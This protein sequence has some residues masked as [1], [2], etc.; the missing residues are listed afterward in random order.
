MNTPSL[1]PTLLRRTRAAAVPLSLALLALTA[2]AADGTRKNYTL[3]SGDA[4]ATLKAFSQQSG[5]QIVYPVEAVRGVQTKPVTGD[6]TA[7]E[8]LQRMVQGT[9]L[10]VVEDAKTG[11]LA[12][13]PKGATPGSVAASELSKALKLEDFRVLGSRIRQTE[14][15]G[16]SPVSAYDSEYIRS[17]GAFTL[18]DFLNQIPQTYSG[19]ASG[20]GSTPNELNP[21][22][23]QRTE[24]T[25]PAFNLVLGSS[26]APP[27]Q[28]GVSG[29]SLRGLGSASTL[30]LVDGRRVAQS[31]AGNRSTDTRQ[32]FV[33]L[34]TI[35][36]GMIDRVEVITDGASAI[37]GADAVAGVINIVLKKEYSGT[38]VQGSFKTAEHGGGRERNTSVLHGFAYGRLSGTVSLE[39]YDRQNLKAS[40]RRFSKNQDHRGIPTS[41]LTADGSTR[42]GNDFR[43]NWGYPAVI[44]ASGGV[45]AGTFDA[46]PGIRVVA[47]PVGATQTPTLSQFIPITTPV[48]TATVVNATGQRRLNTAP[49]LDLI[50]ESKRKG[51]STTFKY[52]LN[53]HLEAFGSGRTSEVRS[54]S[55]AQVAGNSITGG[56]G[57]AAVL[58]AAFNPF[59]QNVQIGMMLPEWGSANQTV[60]TLSD[61]ATGGL[62]GSIGQSW[63]WELG[64]SYQAG[65]TRQKT[66]TYN[67]AGFVAL[68]TATDPAQRFN[69]F[70]DYTAPGAPSQAALLETLSIYP[71]INTE[72][73]SSGI[74]FTADGDLFPFW[75]GDV[76]MAFGGSYN[77]DEV[78][79][80]AIN[81]SATL[82]PVAT[83][84]IFTSDLSTNAV[85]A[86]LQIPVVGKQNGKFFA[87]RLDFQVAGR[88]EEIGP[89]S[90]VVPKYGVSWAP[91]KSV[92]LRGSWSEGFRAPGV[93]EYLFA[94]TTT[95]STLTD[96]RRTP[97]STTGVVVTSG[98]NLDPKVETSENTFAGIVIE[99][100][101]LKGLSLQVN[102][103]DTEQRD[104]LQLLSAQTIVNNEALFTDRIT[105]A[106]PTPADTALNQPGQLTAVNRVF[107]N[108]G[109][110]KN[111]SMDVLVDYTLPYE[112][113]GRWRANVGASRTLEATRALAP[114]QPPVILEDDTS[115]PPKWK[116]NASLFWRGGDWNASAFLW[117]M[118][119]F[120][121][122]NAGNALVANNSAVTYFPTPS[123]TKLDLRVGYEFRKG[124]WRQY[125]K[126]LRVGFGVN[127]VFDKEPPFSD[128]VWG[129]NAG[130]HSQLILGRA[131]EFSFVLP[132]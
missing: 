91:L 105:R 78:Y 48:G 120:Q 15:A 44:Q 27:G 35:P 25:T 39:Y 83:T 55:N 84:T 123:V 22:F 130:L 117:Y 40:E 21:E 3:P 32:G 77:H 102:Y 17:S 16:P 88:R 81:Y 56:F 66:R 60:R 80:Q 20:R 45:V 97:T 19:I 86:E 47:V 6:L 1:I 125:G 9:D 57:T 79:S 104:V 108:F 42:F 74:D 31:G 65:K 121:S 73:T 115:A 4:A 62:R 8:A 132:L 72:R 37:Y 128:T 122:N 110:V 95:T 113:F 10:T 124:V 114:G 33:D 58:P 24:S 76:K 49:F 29:V 14:T 82:V 129:F 94:T 11:A 46:L 36:L 109:E 92:L 100:P 96:P 111:R 101:F 61:A 119:G 93:T 70:I 90:T 51:V 7:R 50:P 30:V 116:I 98:A 68:M 41:I 118:D 54:V 99:P 34:N 53:E 87:E 107:V 59:N 23:G 71:E 2:S 43:L 64:G 85:F 131:Y 126:G 38:E 75:G 127:N 5:E 89:F 112:R 28:T 52:Q 103:Y 69:P 18:A 13:Y 26:A 12:V 63:Q 106:A 67:G